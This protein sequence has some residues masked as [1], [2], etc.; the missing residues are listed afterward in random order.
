MLYLN[1]VGGTQIIRAEHNPG[2][3]LQLHHIRTSLIVIYGRVFIAPKLLLFSDAYFART[4][5][6]KVLR[7]LIMKYARVSPGIQKRF[8]CVLLG[9]MLKIELFNCA[10]ALVMLARPL[11]AV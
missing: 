9:N 4:T 5:P 1:T 11:F 6:K 2:F 8:P 3:I 10:V 7:S